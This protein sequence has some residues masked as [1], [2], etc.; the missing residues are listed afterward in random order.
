MSTPEPLAKAPDADVH[1]V[2]G[3]A[4]PPPPAAGAPA[5]TPAA[6]VPPAPAQPAPADGKGKRKS[7]K[8]KG[9][10]TSDA[11]LGAPKDKL[12]DLDVRVP[13]SVRKR[14]RAEANARGL[15]PDAIVAAILDAA[16]DDRP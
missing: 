3:P 10:A 9:K 12:V 1:P 16:L 8:R 2:T 15:S 5:P 11:L 14:L 4:V 6:P 7:L 13:K